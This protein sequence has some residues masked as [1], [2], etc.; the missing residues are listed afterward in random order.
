M[1]SYILLEK[2]KSFFVYSGFHWNI[3]QPTFLDICS[4]FLKVVFSYDTHKKWDPFNLVLSK[5]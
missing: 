3:I 2:S 5:A 4:Q 1:F